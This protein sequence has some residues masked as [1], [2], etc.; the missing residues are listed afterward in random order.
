[1]QYISETK[2]TLTLLLL[3]VIMVISVLELKFLSIVLIFI[4]L[5]QIKHIDHWKKRNR[6]NSSIL[7]VILYMCEYLSQRI[8][9]AFV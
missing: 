9:Y 7:C 3:E 6:T 5:L 4:N 8:S 2:R 1:M